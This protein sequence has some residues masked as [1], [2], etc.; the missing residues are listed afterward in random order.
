MHFVLITCTFI[1]D[2]IA[3]LSFDD[4]DDDGG[5]GGGY[6]TYSCVFLWES[7]CT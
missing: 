6:F 2:V 7:S 3:I 5:G 1:F 4:D